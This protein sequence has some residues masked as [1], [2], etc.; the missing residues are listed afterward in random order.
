M[1]QQLARNESAQ[2]HNRY[3]E[4][5]CRLGDEVGYQIR[6]ENVTSDAQKLLEDIKAQPKRYVH[7]S[8]FGAKD[9][10]SQQNDR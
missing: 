1:S 2:Q 3:L 4:R 10:S 7:F 8:L 5:Q 6:F 9:K